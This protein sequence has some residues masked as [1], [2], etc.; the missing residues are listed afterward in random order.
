MHCVKGGGFLGISLLDCTFHALPGP[1]LKFIIMLGGVNHTQR[2]YILY[3]FTTAAFQ[4]YTQ[5]F[6]TPFPPLS[7]LPEYTDIQENVLII[8]PTTLNQIYKLS[9]SLSF[10]GKLMIQ[11]RNFITAF[12]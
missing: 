8:I 3:I 1:H 5:F 10:V 9:L 4:I 2:I 11:M 7:T 6:N 12:I